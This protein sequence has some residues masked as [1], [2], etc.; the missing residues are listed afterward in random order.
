MKKILSLIVTLVFLSG[1]AETLAFLGPVSSAA[2]G[3]NVVH[4]T[5]STAVSYGVKKQTGLSPSEHALGYVKKHNPQN[6]KEKCLEFI[7]ATNSEACAAIKTNISE[8]KKKIVKVKKSILDKSK[9]ENL[10]KKSGL[11]R[12]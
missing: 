4:S 8:T 11:V 12:R 9:I 5:I 2:G 10:A 6:K 1:C 7:D 3:G